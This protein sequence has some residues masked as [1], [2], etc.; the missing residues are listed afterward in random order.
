MYQRTVFDPSSSTNSS[1]V[2]DSVFATISL[3]RGRAFSACL[4]LVHRGIRPPNRPSA[5]QAVQA[6]AGGSLRGGR[7]GGL[8]AGGAPGAAAETSSTTRA[9]AT[10]HLSLTI[11]APPYPTFANSRVHL[12]ELTKK[13]SRTE[14]NIFV[15]ETSKSDRI[16]DRWFKVVMI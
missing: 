6:M 14:K 1:L 12:H 7:A 16:L 9:A 11:V 13:A 4:G 3:I 2:S 10:T 8:S 5:S 15:D